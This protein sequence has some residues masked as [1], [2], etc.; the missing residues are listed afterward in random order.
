MK[1]GTADRRILQVLADEPGFVRV[2][3]IAELVNMDPASTERHLHVLDIWGFVTAAQDLDGSGDLEFAITSKALLDGKR[4][5][6][7]IV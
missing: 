7:L 3:R 1:S 2:A 5:G 6:W 4:E